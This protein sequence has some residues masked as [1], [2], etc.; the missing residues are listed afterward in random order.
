MAQPIPYWQ[1]TT[2]A[3]RAED[4]RKW[5]AQLS[6]ASIMLPDE[7]FDRSNIYE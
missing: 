2:P 4:F 5:V 7:A 1:N 3:E 6:G